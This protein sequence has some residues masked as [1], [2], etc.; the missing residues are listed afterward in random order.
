[1]PRT[2]D[3]SSL[4]CAGAPETFVLVHMRSICAESRSK[5]EIREKNISLLI[6]CVGIHL[7]ALLIANLQA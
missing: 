3:S 2:H 4:I 7:V 1:M 5:A 6:N